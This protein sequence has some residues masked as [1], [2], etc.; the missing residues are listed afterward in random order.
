MRHRIGDNC[1]ALVEGV[2]IRRGIWD[3]HQAELETSQ[4]IDGFSAWRIVRCHDTYS[5][6]TTELLVAQYLMVLTRWLVAVEANSVA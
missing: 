4:G 1:R 3:S 2:L 6:T 5:G